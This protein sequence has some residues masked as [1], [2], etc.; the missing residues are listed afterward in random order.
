MT[1][2]TSFKKELI[3][4]FNSIGIN[5]GQDIYATGNI[6]K[7]ARARIPKEQILKNIN[8]ALRSSIGHNGTIFSPAASMN[9]CNT[10]VP[11]D[12][13]DTPSHEMGPLAE[14]LRKQTN[15]L[16][17]FHPFWSVCGNGL[18]SEI[19]NNV[20]RHSY[21]LF[22]PWS[23]F[24]D[25]DVMQVNFGLHPSKAVTL[26]HHIETTV[27]VP[28]RYTKEFIHPVIRANKIVHEPF[29]MSVM[30]NGAGIEKRKK[31]NEHYFE[32]MDSSGLIHHAKH[33]S[34]VDVWAF[35]MK[36]FYNTVKPYFLE[37]IYNYLEFP[38]KVRPY[39]D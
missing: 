3:N 37:N 28:Y 21:G 7:F 26:I 31:L 17:S 1:N 2:E 13:K 39:Q 18:N 25:L 22:S 10:S 27:G 5:E 33:K 20:T 30:Y 38:P 29:Y 19:L 9:L 34:G 16:R 24:L 32:A 8:E 36:D 6:S 35:K 14:Y 12:L 11:F 15:T 4:L 23:Y